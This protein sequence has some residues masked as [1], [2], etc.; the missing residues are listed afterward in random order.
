MSIVKM[1]RGSYARRACNHCRR[2]YVTLM[3]W[4]ARS[5]PTADRAGNRSAMAVNRSVRPAEH[6]VTKYA[7][8]FRTG[9]DVVLIH[10]N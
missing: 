10:Y 4:S 2:R 9:I 7:R 1:K 3:S 5:P 8:F 6:L